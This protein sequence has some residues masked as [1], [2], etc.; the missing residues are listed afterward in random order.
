M[1]MRLL[2]ATCA[3]AAFAGIVYCCFALWA[4]RKFRQRNRDDLCSKFAPPLSIIKPLCGVDP[5]AYERLAVHCVQYYSTY[6][7]IFGVS[8]HDDP[9]VPLVK[10]LEAEFPEIPMR[11]IVCRLSGMNLKVSNILQMLPAAQHEYLVIND[12]DIAVPA[13]YLRR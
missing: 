6:Q 7:I 13:D 8:D 10:Q 12:S 5:H 1:L 9:V 2:Q 11:L 3:L 4:V